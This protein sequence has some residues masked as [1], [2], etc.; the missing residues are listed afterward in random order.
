MSMQAERLE[1]GITR[2][3]VCDGDGNRSSG[4]AWNMT[5]LGTMND[6]ARECAHREWSL[7]KPPKDHTRPSR[8]RVS[9][10]PQEHDDAASAGNPCKLKV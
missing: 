1:K 2:N 6:L 3:P 10:P 9:Q 8:N 7:S 4:K 5:V